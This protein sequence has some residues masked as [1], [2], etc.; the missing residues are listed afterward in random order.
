MVDLVAQIC[1]QYVV[2]YYAWCAYVI[3][4]SFTG[5][6]VDVDMVI[7][8]CGYQMAKISLYILLVIM[9]G[10]LIFMQGV[11]RLSK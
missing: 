9:Q 10:V 6:H 1:I 8:V 4:S 5:I 2:R 3:V 7:P 11:S